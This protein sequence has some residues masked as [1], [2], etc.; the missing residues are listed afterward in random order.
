MD[1]ETTQLKN[2]EI[3]Y[4]KD[5]ENIQLKD[6]EKSPHCHPHLYLMEISKEY[7]PICFK[8]INEVHIDT[9]LKKVDCFCGNCRILLTYGCTYTC[10]GCDFNEYNAHFISKWKNKET[11]QV[12]N[13]MPKI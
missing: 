12:Y 5:L 1:L 4:L 2:V 9:L 8:Y 6:L 3:T 11:S 7:C 10:N 13:G